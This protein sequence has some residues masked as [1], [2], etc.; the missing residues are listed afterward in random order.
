MIIKSLDAT[1]LYKLLGTS[2]A[3]KR[4]PEIN[5]TVLGVVAQLACSYALITLALLSGGFESRRV[6]FF[7]KKLRNLRKSLSGQRK[8]MALSDLTF[9]TV[10]VL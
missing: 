2:A 5:P 3:R 7:R 9:A 6:Q 4:A 8:K 1:S 10:P